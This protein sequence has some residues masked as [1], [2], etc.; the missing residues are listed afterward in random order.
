MNQDAL[1]LHF[2]RCRHGASEDL[3]ASSYCMFMFLLPAMAQVWYTSG[4]A[5][6]KVVWCRGPLVVVNAELIEATGSPSVR[7]PSIRAT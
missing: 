7:F 4:Y 6:A 3:L 2:A 5:I 1:K